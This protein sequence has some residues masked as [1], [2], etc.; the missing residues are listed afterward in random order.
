MRSSDPVLSLPQTRRSGGRTWWL[1]RRLRLNTS[2]SSAT[3]PSHKQ[4]MAL[5]TLYKH[6]RSFC[7]AAQ[8]F[9]PLVVAGDE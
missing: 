3:A 1:A 4:R 9:C 5:K 8:G 2:H 7:E 6:L